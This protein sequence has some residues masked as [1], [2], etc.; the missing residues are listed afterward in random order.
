MTAHPSVVEQMLRDLLVPEQDFRVVPL[1]DRPGY[2]IGRSHDDGIV[3]LTPSDPEPRH[4]VKLRRLHL[5]PRMSCTVTHQDG[6]S[7]Q[8]EAGIVAYY[9]GT[10]DLVP[11]FIRVAEALADL[12]GP[13]PAPG[14][15]SKQ[16]ARLVRL[17]EPSQPPRGS[18]V[19][20]WGELLTILS[21]ADVR[22]MLRA[23]H[24][25]I[26]EKFDFSAEGSRLEVKTSSGAERIHRFRLHQ[27]EPVPGAQVHV[28]SITTAQA[29]DG[30]SVS[31]L[32]G[33][34]IAALAGDPAAVL[35]LHEQVVGT[36]GPD[37]ATS[38]SRRFDEAQGLASMRLLDASGIPRV[39]TP[40]PEVVSVELAIDCSNVPATSPAS[41]G[42]LAR[43]VHSPAPVA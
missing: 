17:F 28:V 26:D 31:D 33:R 11:H 32:V 10:D 38:A 35:S 30:A 3:L 12:L 19:G 34:L 9:P 37:W 40:P 13:A 14:E 6:Q 23:W 22:Q 7:E 15:V 5:L 4:P 18:E 25:K 16:M 42:G 1:P 27:L 21:A 29:H 20:L 8:L 39:G 2:R 43:L 36:L 41:A 24:A